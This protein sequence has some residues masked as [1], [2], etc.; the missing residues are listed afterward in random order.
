M[1]ADGF[2]VSGCEGSL[3]ESDLWNRLP[4]T[5]TFASVRPDVWGF[6]PTT[7]EFAF[8]EAKCS[9][10]IVNVHTRKQLLVLGQLLRRDTRTACRLYVAVCRSDALALDRILAQTGLLR[11]P[12]VVRLHIPDCFITEGRNECA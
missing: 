5:P 8:G 12:N 7:G 10:D 2:I 4:G 1:T 9:D 11:A 3:P 6:A